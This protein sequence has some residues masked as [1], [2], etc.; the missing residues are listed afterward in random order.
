MTY[1]STAYILPNHCPLGTSTVYLHLSPVFLLPIST[2]L[3]NY[4]TSQQM[5][6]CRYSNVSFSK[7][8]HTLTI[9]LLTKISPKFETE[10]RPHEAISVKQACSLF[11]TKHEAKRLWCYHIFLVSSDFCILRLLFICIWVHK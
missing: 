2:K 5:L 4:V 3:D 11:N 10:D 6:S 7:H 8:T 1:S 9:L